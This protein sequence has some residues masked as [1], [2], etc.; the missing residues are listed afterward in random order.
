MAAGVPG[1]LLQPYAD[2]FDGRSAEK[3]GRWLAP[4]LFF[5]KQAA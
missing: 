2:M 1:P 5:P 4:R 3:L